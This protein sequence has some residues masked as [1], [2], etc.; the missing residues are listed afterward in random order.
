MKFL[1]I[2]VLATISIN[3]QTSNHNSHDENSKHHAYHNHIALFLGG[4]TFYQNSGSHFS[5]G[6][7]Y[8]YRPNNENPWAYS[9][10]AEAIFAEHTEYVIAIP[11]YH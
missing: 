5:L 3:A 7:D 10:M 1:F 8:L 4:T 2:M 9:I 11:I 6:L